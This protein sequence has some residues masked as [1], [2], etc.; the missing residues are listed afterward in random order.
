MIASPDMPDFFIPGAP[1]AGTT[2]LAGWLAAHPGVGFC[3]LKEPQFFNTD[4]RHPH[5][6]P[7]LDDYF[8][9]FPPR[10]A[11]GLR[12]EAT[13]GYLV[14][15][16]AIA[17][18]LGLNPSAKF[19][20]CLRDPVSLFISLH[21][22][23][24]KEGFEVLTDPR[25]AWRASEKRRAG[26]AVPL[27]CPDG[28]MLD[29]PRYAALGDQ[30]EA[31]LAQ[32]PRAQVLCLHSEELSNSPQVAFERSCA[33]LGLDKMPISAPTRANPARIPRSPRI[34]QTMRALGGVRRR[35]GFES[36]FGIASRIERLNLRKPGETFDPVLRAELDALLTPQ[37]DKLRDLIGR[38]RHDP[39]C[40][41]T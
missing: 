2:S 33:F 9:L 30:M 38:A 31:L 37:R 20:I 36:G 10:P 7:T 35:L 24:L 29:Y 23:R 13:T 26:N 15:R 17:A 34:A 32:V 22:Q 18:I 16:T 3:S 4:F 14:S 11:G 6:P 1:K 12:G 5:R 41:P 40:D 27:T 21:R 19:V 25:A 8:A 39:P 28:Q